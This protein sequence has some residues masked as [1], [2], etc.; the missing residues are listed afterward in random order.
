MASMEVEWCCRASSPD[1][2]PEAAGGKVTMPK[3][4][5]AAC[6][7]LQAVNMTRGEQLADRMH[8]HGASESTLQINVRIVF[9]KTYSN[10]ALV[11]GLP[12]LQGYC[13]SSA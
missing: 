2:L 5:A 9:M 8:H 7:S 1:G 12:K 11:S 10:D 6:S 13:A 3:P 4:P